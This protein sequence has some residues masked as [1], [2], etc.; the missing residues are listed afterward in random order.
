MPI[1][2]PT[3][4]RY[5]SDGAE[6]ATTAFGNDVKSAT[7]H[8]D[9]AKGYK[10]RIASA[11]YLK[12]HVRQYAQDFGSNKRVYKKLYQPEQTTITI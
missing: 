5:Y 8:S 7:K 9:G 10:G 3:N 6:S 4:D 2:N 12:A 11:E 1:D